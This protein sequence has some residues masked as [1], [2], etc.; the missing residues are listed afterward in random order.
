MNIGLCIVTYNRLLYLKQV[1]R[2][3]EEHNWGG[4][5]IKGIIDDGSTQ[6]GYKEYLQELRQKGYMVLVNDKNSGVARTKN[7]ALNY[8]MNTDCEHLFIMEDDILMKNNKTCIHYI[9]YGMLKKIKHLNFGKHGEHNNNGMHFYNGVF[10][11]PNI[12]GAFSYYHKDTIKKIGYFDENFLNAF[13]HVEHTYRAGLYGFTT[14]FWHFSDLPN[15]TDLLQE[16]PN[17]INNSVIRPRNDWQLNIKNAK[18]YWIKKYGSWL[19]ER[20]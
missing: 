7:R 1:I 13:E 16:I 14:P 6:E 10:C 17:S 19:P 15:S 12:V 2:S 8:M 20:K 3:L 9:A 4:A 5:N 18:E 11:Y